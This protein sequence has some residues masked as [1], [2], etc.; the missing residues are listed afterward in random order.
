[1]ISRGRTL[2]PNLHFPLRQLALCLDC[3]ECFEIRPETTCPACGSATWTS[4]SRFLEQAAS[5]RRLRRRQV[6]L[7][8][9]QLHDDEPDQVRQLVSVASEAEQLY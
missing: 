4:L 2:V 1:M 5:S 3:E 7:P 8:A 6:S 9:P